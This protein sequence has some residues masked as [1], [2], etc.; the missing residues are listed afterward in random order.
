MA[1][2]YGIH[3]GDCV[4]LLPQVEP[5]SVRLAFADP[6]FNLG[7]GYDDNFDDRRPDGE[8]LA[9]LR[10]WISLTVPTLADD[11]SFWLAINEKYAAE[12]KI[13]CTD[14]GLH[15]RSWIIWHYTFGQNMRKQFAK[16]NTHILYFTKHA[17]SFVFNDLQ[18]R[19]P[20]S[21]QL[22]GDR[23]AHPDGKVPDS[24]WG[25]FP[26]VCGTY[27]EKQAW[28][29][30]QMPEQLLHR[31]IRVAS[32]AG[33]LV[34]DPFSGSATTS[35]AAARLGRRYLSFDLSDEYCTLGQQ[36]IEEAIADPE[37]TILATGKWGPFHSEAAK[38]LFRETGASAR[39]LLEKPNALA[40]F[41]RLLNFRCGGASYTTED[42]AGILPAIESCGLPGNTTRPR[43]AAATGRGRRP[44][45]AETR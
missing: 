21:R 29:D 30:N 26:R 11:G 13:A 10:E 33:D 23:R 24:T 19:V 22:Y 14:Q 1:L 18:I 44:A 7:R 15:L 3:H 32:D 38:W 2:K 43:A 42:I 17:R 40:C 5:G 45:T 41:T 39:E 4:D 25:E 9:W 35:V 6:P 34:L 20:S 12:I 27:A 31:I 36:R 16:S 28:H 8:Y 37:N